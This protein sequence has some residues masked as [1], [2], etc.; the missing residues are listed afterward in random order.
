M[1]PDVSVIIPV[2]N[3]EKLIERCLCSVDAQRS[4]GLSLE[5]IIVD[6]GS[7]DSSGK[8]ADD[9]AGTHEAATVI[10]TAHA[11]PGEARNIGLSSAKGRWIAFVDSDDALFENCLVCLI[12][13]GENANADIVIGKVELI[14]SD[15]ST[16]IVPDVN[17]ATRLDCKEALRLLIL[18]DGIRSYIPGKIFRRERIKDEPLTAGMF[19]EDMEWMHRVFGKCDSILMTDILT[20]KYFRRADSISGAMNM[21]HLDLVESMRRRYEYIKAN[22]PGLAPLTA[23]MFWHY[24][25]LMMVTSKC[26]KIEGAEKFKVL[27]KD[28]E[29]RYGKEFDRYL[30]RKFIYRAAKLGTIPYRIVFRFFPNLAK[31][32]KA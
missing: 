10:H 11:G 4:S 28:I 15:G 1:K 8:I 20:Y 6:D 22:F 31:P 21:Y 25:Y 2:Y 3:T 30:G 7:T 24:S 26:Q 18:D 32:S 29:R 19:F 13:S 9:Y 16:E 12:E 14:R 17:T 5:V 23:E 27:Y